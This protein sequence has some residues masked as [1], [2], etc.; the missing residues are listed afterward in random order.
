MAP[1]DGLVRDKQCYVSI[2][3]FLQCFAIFI[4]FLQYTAFPV[5]KLPF[6]HSGK[7]TG[8]TAPHFLPPL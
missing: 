2:Y 4:A 6:L 7:S 3:N 5:S 1:L 8:S